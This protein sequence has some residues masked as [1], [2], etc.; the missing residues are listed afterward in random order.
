MSSRFEEDTKTQIP[1]D[2][3]TSTNKTTTP[4]TE[5]PSA[6]NNQRQKKQRQRDRQRDRT[7]ETTPTAVSSGPTGTPSVIFEEGPYINQRIPQT[8][9]D[10]YRFSWPPTL[11]RPTSSPDTSSSTTTEEEEDSESS[12]TNRKKRQ[13]QTQQKQ[14]QEGEVQAETSISPTSSTQLINTKPEAEPQSEE[15]DTASSNSTATTTNKNGGSNKQK[16]QQ[17][18]NSTSSSSSSSSSETPTQFP[19]YLTTTYY[20][21]PIWP[22]YSPTSFEQ[23]PTTKRQ[24]ITQRE[25]KAQTKKIA[26]MQAAGLTYPPSTS[27]SPTTTLATEIP[28]HNVYHRVGSDSRFGENTVHRPF[29]HGGLG[30]EVI[31]PTPSPSTSKPTIEQPESTSTMRGPSRYTGGGGRGSYSSRFDTDEPTTAVVEVNSTK[32]IE[33]IEQERFGSVPTPMPVLSSVRGSGG[34]GG[35][36]WSGGYERYASTDD[37]T[38]NPTGHP[39]SEEPTTGTPTLYDGTYTPTYSPIDAVNN[40]DGMERFGGRHHQTPA[41]TTPAPTTSEPSPKPTRAKMDITIRDASPP[42]PREPKTSTK[43]NL[44]FKLTGEPTP[45]PNDRMSLNLYGRGKEP[46]TTTLPPVSSSSDEPTYFIYPTFV[47]TGSPIMLRPKT[48]SVTPTLWPSYVPTTDEERV[49]R[50]PSKEQFANERYRDSPYSRDQDLWS[51]DEHEEEEEESQEEEV[52]LVEE[53]PL[54]D[55]LGMSLYE[56]RVCPGQSNGG[57]SSPKIEERVHF[58]YSVQTTHGEHDRT[59]ERNVEIMSLWL[60]EDVATHLLNCVDGVV[61]SVSV[62]RSSFGSR[63][64]LLL[65][66]NGGGIFEQSVSSVYYMENESIATLSKLVFGALASFFHVHDRDYSHTPSLFLLFNHHTICR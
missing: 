40:D 62:E 41:P 6:S 39:I 7:F 36:R 24:M 54:L 27:I 23:M 26:D 10:R 17:Q 28:T 3:S 14:Q 19:T 29:N 51:G 11:P 46:T 48:T 64:A 56:K 21:T 42:S 4:T 5:E 15:E 18:S 31:L 32:T 9:R 25:K 44:T 35:G 37:P 63:R 22:T 1:I 66:S 20:P 53:D 59:I 55:D 13:K 34:G 58:T 52:V 38:S 65:L 60:L 57:N 49:R 43:L 12:N 33:E 30:T 8:T 47:P 2:N 50:P 45:S 61:K 16:N